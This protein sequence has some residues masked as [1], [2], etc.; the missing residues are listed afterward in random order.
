LDPQDGNDRKTEVF[1][2]ISGAKIMAVSVP[3]PIK[4]LKQNKQCKQWKVIIQYVSGGIVNILG[5]GSMDYS[6]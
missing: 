6:D 1:L 2:L 3:V 4:N 5:G